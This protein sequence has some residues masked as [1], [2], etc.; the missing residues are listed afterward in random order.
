MIGIRSRLWSSANC[1]IVLISSAHA[2]R[3]VADRRPRAAAGEDRA[4]LVLLEDVGMRSGLSGPR[5]H[6]VSGVALEDLDVDLAHLADL[7]G[8]RHAP[9]QVG[10]ALVDRPRGVLVGRTER[11][12]RRPPRSAAVPAARPP[13]SAASAAKRINSRTSDCA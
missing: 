13:S 9:E 8:E 1:W 6:G 7:L 12:R 2:L 3:V 5:S 11:S 4:D 10:D